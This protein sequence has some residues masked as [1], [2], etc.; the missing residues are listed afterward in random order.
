MKQIPLAIQMRPD[1]LSDVVGQQHLIGDNKILSNIIKH[2]HLFS[3]ILYGSPGIGKTT[4][5]HVI[6]KELDLEYISLNAT[7]NNKK[8][9]ET[10]IEEAKENSKVI[11]IDEIHRMNKDKQD[12]LLPF[13]E[14]GEIIVIGMTSE[15]P[16]HK[17][18]PAI[19]SRCQIFKLTPLNEDDIKIAIH[20]LINKK[21]LKLLEIDDDVINS[22]AKLSNGDLR[23]VFNLIEVAYYSTADGHITKEILN[24]ID[25]KPNIQIDSSDEGYYDTISAL[26]KSIRGSDVDASLHY[27]AKLIVAEELDILY[28]R[29]LVIAYEDIGLANPGIGP[30]T[31]AAI[32]TA[33]M[34]GLPEARIPIGDIIIEMALSPKS[35]TA[36]MAFDEAIEDIENGNNGVVPSHLKTHSSS[37]KY[38]HD[39]PHA[40]VKQQYM[41]DNL[42]NKEYYKPKDGGQEKQFKETYNNI[43]KFLDK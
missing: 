29:L 8:D 39:Y 40:I 20:N 42:K 26:Q 14:S 43:R 32:Q 1:K 15:N 7:I 17:L 33:E 23:Y 27:A 10:A 28:R 34:L 19:R 31:V 6:L 22:I 9:F 13:L 35:N 12:I 38:P 24:E 36:H 25:S 37:Y 16:Y 4:L 5:A 41:P 2:K 18:N 30:K 11:L 21:I 3:F